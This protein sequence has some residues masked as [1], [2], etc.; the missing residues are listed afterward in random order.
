MNKQVKQI[1][2][3]IERRIREDYNGDEHEDEI[4]QGVCASMLYYINSLEEEPVSKFD[5]CSQEGD[6]IVT[7]ENGTRFNVSQLERV[8]VSENLEKEIKDIQ[9][10]YKEHDCNYDNDIDFIARHFAKWNKEQTCKWL[11]EHGMTQHVIER[12]RK[13]MEE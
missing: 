5:S 10:D 1:K 4:A 9:Q 12:Y 2:T 11:L 6:K 8:S 13:D 3:E 7:N